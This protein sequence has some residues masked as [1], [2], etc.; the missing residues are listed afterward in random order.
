[1]AT[2]LKLK[3]DIKKLKA[4][5]NSKA[6]PK[7]FL[8]KLKNQ[9]ERAEGELKSLKEAPKGGKPKKST[10]AGT[11]KTLTA[12]EKLVNKK[13]YSVYKGRG[14]DLKKDAGEGAFQTGR[15][16]SKGLKSNQYGSAKE[17]KGNVYY[18]YRPNRL[19]VKQPKKKQTYPKLE[20]GGILSKEDFL[21]EIYDMAGSVQVVERSSDVQLSTDNRSDLKPFIQKYAEFGKA[22]YGLVS[23]IDEVKMDGET[24]YYLTIKYPKFADGGIMADGG[25]ISKEDF[26]KKSIVYDNGGKSLD[27]Y[28]VFTPDGSVY[29][30]SETAQGFNQYV[31]ESDEISK[32]SHLGKRLKSVPKEIEW[33]VIRRMEF[34]DG[35]MMAKG[36]EVRYKLKGSNFGQQIE[37]GQKFKALISKVHANQTGENK[38]PENLIKEIAYTGKIVKSDGSNYLKDYAYKGTLTKFEFL[39]DKDFIEALKYVDRPAIRKFEEG[40]EIPEG[41]QTDILNEGDYVWNAVGKKLVVDRV[42]EDEYYLS[43][44]MQK[45]DSPFSKEKV[46]EYIKTGQWSLSPK[47]ASGGEVKAKYKVGD[48]VYSYQNKD[49]P[50]PISYTTEISYPNE[51][52]KYKLKLKDG[53]SN[54][55]NEDSL[56]KSKMASGGELHRSEEKYAEGGQTKNF[57]E[58]EFKDI[59]DE[60]LEHLYMGL[61]KIE[62]AM[63]YLEVRGQAGMKNPFAAKIGLSNLKESIEKIDEYTSKK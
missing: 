13:K 36:G 59:L 27:R 63:R 22:G 62:G 33:A 38:Y 61:N 10:S 29:A 18:E 17:N 47:M 3:S 40:G 52:V 14:V 21:D 56:S 9:L 46:N 60:A 32:G 23:E 48:M 34:A 45:G 28:T 50:A 5:I 54:W 7:S 30:M 25:E 2:A 16:V 55:I 58:R 4:A 12:L 1:M 37:N 39:D 19:D 43:G 53:Y 57:N 42:T 11:E 8:P 49:Y 26:L 31:G 20:D 15:R 6:T 24:Y 41:G 35:G 51:K 44:F